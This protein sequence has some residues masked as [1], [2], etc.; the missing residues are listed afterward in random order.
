[1]VLSIISV[2]DVLPIYQRA[3]SG[4]LFSRVSPAGSQ[5]QLERYSMIGDVLAAG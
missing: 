3:D 4:V 1:M 5:L 2:N